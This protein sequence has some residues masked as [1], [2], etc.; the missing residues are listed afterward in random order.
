MATRTPW[1]TA[2]SKQEYGPGVTFYGTPSHGG[3]RV[4]P[5]LNAKMPE[6]LRDE[7]GWYEEDCAWANVAVAFPERFK[8]AEIEAALGTLKGWEPE[9]YEKLTGLV[10]MPGESRARDEVI[11]TAENRHHMVTLAAAGSGPGRSL[12]SRTGDVPEGFVEVFA[13]RGGRLDNGMYPAETAY[14]LVPEAEY[15]ARRGVG[16]F[17]VDE[18]RHKLVK[19]GG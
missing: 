12:A 13:G 18:A 16:W 6:Y 8:P 5:K 7:S 2:D 11:F 15:G 19:R 4:A 10:L 9:A 3:F 14:Y 17:V 1:G